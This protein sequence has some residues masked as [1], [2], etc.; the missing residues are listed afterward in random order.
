M[1]KNKLI[2]FDW[3]NIVESHTTGYSCYD[4]FNDLFKECGYDGKE[5]VFHLLGKYKLSAIKSVDD[6]GKVY[7]I[8][9]KDFKLNKSYSEF[10]DI[11]K[12][13]FSKIYY[14]K[15]VA[16]YEVS[17]RD[18]CYIG[19]LSNL[20]VFDKERLD[21]QVNLSL[22]DY[23]FLSFEL[24]LK[25]PNIDIYEYVLDH[26]PFEPDDILFIDDRL[27][28]IEMASKMGWNVLQATGLE[29]DKIKEKCE[30]FLNQ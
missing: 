7:E 25:K 2:L 18:K 4:A 11:Y 29:L 17:L 20:T 16:E 5:E 3:G 30:D 21:K 27:D 22:Y 26:L 19:I 10:I 14:Y 9:A 15:D 23:V 1:K 8:M 28:N 12:K 24:G 13:V 6:F